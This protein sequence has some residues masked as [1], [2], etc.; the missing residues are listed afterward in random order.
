MNH[1]RVQKIKWRKEIRPEFLKRQRL[2]TKLKIS[3]ELSIKIF[4]DILPEPHEI[5]ILDSLL[6]NDR[7]EMC[8]M[9]RPLLQKVVGHR[10]SVQVAKKL[11][12]SDSRLRG[13]L[14]GEVDSLSYDII[15]KI[16][17]YLNHISGRKISPENEELAKYY[18]R[19]K[20]DNIQ[21]TM[22]KIGQDIQFGSYYFNSIEKM[23]SKN[24]LTEDEKYRIEQAQSQIINSIKRLEEV[25]EK[26]ES[27]RKAYL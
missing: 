25:K 4:D 27:L 15:L 13:F 7:A 16:E 12:I 5:D 14:K 2:L 23:T 8:E 3:Q 20:L 26:F 19:E 1:T 6:K 10:E 21:Q 11:D 18:I 9:L 17:H 22:N 24:K